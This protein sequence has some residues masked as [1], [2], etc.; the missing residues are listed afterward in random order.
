MTPKE[1][2]SDGLQDPEEAQ[3]LGLAST[4]PGSTWPGPARQVAPRCADGAG[5][6]AGGSAFLFPHRV[7][8]ALMTH[9]RCDELEVQLKTGKCLHLTRHLL[10]PQAL[11]SGLVHLQ[12]VCSSSAQSS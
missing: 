3:G 1:R 7:A 10:G 11:L 8:L 2:R 12:A 4:W 9:Q 5:A 6:A